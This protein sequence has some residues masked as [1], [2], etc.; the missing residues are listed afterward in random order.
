MIV[1]LNTWAPE[2][3]TAPIFTY[4]VLEVSQKMRES[5]KDIW[6]PENRAVC[7]CFQ[8]IVFELSIMK[9]LAFCVARTTWELLNRYPTR[10]GAPLIAPDESSE[11]SV[12]FTSWNIPELEVVHRALESPT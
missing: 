3:L 2:P 10:I 6:K 9:I 7:C 5:I 12:V 1:D 11:K 4:V 8:E